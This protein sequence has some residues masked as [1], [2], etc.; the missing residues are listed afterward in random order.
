MQTSF[1]TS[2]ADLVEARDGFTGTHIK[3]TS[4]YV[5]TLCHALQKEP[6]YANVLTDDYIELIVEAAP[7]HDIGKISIPDAILQKPG[8]LT[9][10]EFEIIKTHSTLGEQILQDIMKET[11]ENEK[12]LTACKMAKFHH[13]RWD[14]KGYPT[15]LS[16]R[17]I[18]LCARI[19]ALADVYDALRSKRCYK[20]AMSKEKAISI[21]KEGAGTQFDS[22]MTQIFIDC[23]Q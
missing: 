19:M 6:S 17:D 22:E 5:E 11:G 4:H 13:E 2:F 15:G 8:K 12:L 23:I 10:E 14:G 21:I 20:D 3:N 16:G 7:L 18:P 1:I 9:E